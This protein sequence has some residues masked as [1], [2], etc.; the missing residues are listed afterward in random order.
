MLKTLKTFYYF[1]F[2]KK[3][4]FC[5][6]ILLVTLASILTSITPYFFK[7]FVEAIPTLNYQWLLQILFIYLGVNILALAFDVALT[8]FRF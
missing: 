7:L 5:V 4:L 3:L 1:V 2:R 6:I 8:Y